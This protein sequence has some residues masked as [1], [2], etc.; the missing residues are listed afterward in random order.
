MGTTIDRQWLTVELLHQHEDGIYE[1]E[2]IVRYLT[3]FITSKYD[4]KCHTY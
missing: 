4:T 3:F 2:D 1:E